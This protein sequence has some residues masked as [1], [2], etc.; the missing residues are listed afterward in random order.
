MAYKT[1]KFSVNKSYLIGIDVSQH[2]G[3]IDWQKVKDD[4]INFAI[5]RCGYGQ[6]ISSQDDP[7]FLYNVKECERLGIPYGVY[8]YSYAA[9]R[10]GAR[11]EAEHVIRM[12]D[13][14][15]PEFGV[16]I[17]MEDADGY[18]IKYNIPYSVG[19]EIC[20]EFCAYMEEKGYKA[21][22][23]ANLD[24]FTN[25]LNVSYLDRYP[26]WVAQ[27]NSECTYDG[28]YVMWQYT[29]SGKVEGISGNV[30]MNKWYK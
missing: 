12:L 4:G 13:G 20:E 27:W 3:Q 7:Q 25:Y 1:I 23:Y 11:S 29:S 15:N 6:N 19:A 28:K 17:D 10:E 30:D 18:K 9:N 16:W 2:N 24:W 14:R 26:K 8:L 22:I 21:G 5:I